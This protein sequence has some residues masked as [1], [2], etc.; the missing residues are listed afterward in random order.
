MDDLEDICSSYGISLQLEDERVKGKQLAVITF[1]G[2]LRP[3]QRK[4]VDKLL[5]Y[6]N[7][8]LHAPTAFGKTITAIGLI[9]QRK[10]NT[11]VL[12]HN[13]QLVEQWEERLKVFTQD[14]EVGVWTGSKKKP[15][16][17]NDIATY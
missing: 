3:A 14:V 13:K 8:V 15:T 4:A 11:L 12:V 10:I 2:S 5:Q 17:Q 1:V 9:C 16:G 7:G 6:D